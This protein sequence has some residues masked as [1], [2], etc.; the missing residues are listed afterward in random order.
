ME[1]RPAWVQSYVFSWSEETSLLEFVLRPTKSGHKQVRVEF[2]Y[3][4][5]WLAKIQFDV[6]V[7]EAQELVPA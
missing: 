2:Y 3:Q 7:V 6:E 4:R 5:H 1:I